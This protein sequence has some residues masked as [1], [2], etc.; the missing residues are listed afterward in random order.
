MK[1]PGQQDRVIRY[2][3]K[4][5]QKQAFYA[6]RKKKIGPNIPFDLLASNHK[7]SYYEMTPTMAHQHTQGEQ[8]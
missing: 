7:P 3:T 5:Y 6:S 8:Q 4:R 2:S 1:I